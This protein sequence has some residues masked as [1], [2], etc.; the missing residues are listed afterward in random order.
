MAW[1]PTDTDLKRSSATLLVLALVSETP[2]HGYEIGKL[3]TER[4]KGTIT[5]NMASLYPLLYRMERHGWITGEW[6]ERPKERRRRFYRITPEGEH[7]LAGQR[8]LWRGFVSALDQ[9]AGLKES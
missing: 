6:R 9:V 2:R 1:T 8:G 4:S 3:I 5:F 7:V